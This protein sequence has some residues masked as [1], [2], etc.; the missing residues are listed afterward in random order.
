MDFTSQ[1]NNLCMG[2]VGLP[3]IGKSTLFN[4]LTK[5]SVP[6]ANYPF[7]TRDPNDGI[8][9][10]PDHR[11]D[12]LSSL[13][14]PKSTVFATLAV[15]DIAGLVEGASEGRGLGNEFL[16]HIRG[17]DGI[18]HVVQ[19]FEE[20][21]IVRSTPVDPLADIKIVEEELR[22]RDLST[23]EKQLAKRKAPPILSKL[24]EVLSTRWVS[25]GEWSADEVKEIAKMNLLTTKKVVY[26]AN[27]GEEEYDFICDLKREKERREKSENADVDNATGII[28]KKG[29]VL[30]H[31]KKIAHLKPLIFTRSKVDFKELC[32]KGYE[33]LSLIN[34]FTAGSDEVRAWTIKAH[35]EICYAGGVIHSDF[36]THFITAEVMKYCDFEKYGSEVETRKAGKVGFRGKGYYVEDGDIIHFRAGKRK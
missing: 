30:K 29:L 32:R 17:T 36:S 33:A 34:F 13:Y 3:N 9:H 15:T 8:V 20:E 12:F 35:T 21:E 24:R 22:L 7:C 27:V 10:I 16:E 4:L 2:I 11:I 5:Q 14:R 28:K 23:I 19:C 25:Q 26:C 6:S 31:L 1:S 18:F